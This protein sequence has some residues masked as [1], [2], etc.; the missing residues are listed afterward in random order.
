MAQS[1]TSTH[2]PTPPP[3][4][5]PAPI[6]LDDLKQAGIA[7]ASEA[8]GLCTLILD[9]GHLLPERDREKLYT[10]LKKMTSEIHEEGAY[11]GQLVMQPYDAPPVRQPS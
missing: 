10:G 5:E 7:L 2:T 3:K 8:S 9:K 4:A 1:S 6:T 11:T